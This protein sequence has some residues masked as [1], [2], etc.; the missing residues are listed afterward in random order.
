[1]SSIAEKAEYTPE[2]LLALPDEKDY[3][4]VDGQLVERNM[5]ALSSWVGGRVFRFLSGWIEARELGF[6]WPADNGFQCFPHDPRRVRKPDVSFVSQE[7]LPAGLP[8]EGWLHVVP[9][10]VVEVLSANDLAVEVDEKLDDYRRAG[11]PLIWVIN[12]EARTVTVYGANTY[13][14]LSENDELAGGEVLSGFRCRVADLFP[15]R[16]TAPLADRPEIPAG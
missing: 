1:M 6:L 3:E 4:L 12:P 10:L 8:A 14:R 11:V 7:K 16:P 2:E 9:D 5:G 13:V 15:P